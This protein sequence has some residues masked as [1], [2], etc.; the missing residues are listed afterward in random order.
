M[1]KRNLAALSTVFDIPVEWRSTP[2][3]QFIKAQNMD[4]TIFAE[5]RAKVMMSACMECRYSIPIPSNFAYVVRTP[6][7][8]LTGTELAIGYAISR[9]VEN[10]IL[11]AHNDCGMTKLTK[12]K[13][14]IINTLIDQGWD[15]KKATEFV[16]SEQ[17]K[18]S[19]DNELESLR[20][21]YLRLKN[22]FKKITIAPLFL[23]LAEQ[24]VYLPKWYA[25]L[26]GSNKTLTTNTKRENVTVS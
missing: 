17:K 21:E 9:G 10:L 4:Y 7:G 3:E 26:Q 14:N 18:L 24:K 1:P 6:G 23:I 20:D 15:E 22:L 13:S 25:Q 16:E 5:S 8:R 11:V 12:F 2:I 19:I